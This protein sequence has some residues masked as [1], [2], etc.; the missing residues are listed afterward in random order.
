M[1]DGHMTYVRTTNLTY[2]EFNTLNQNYEKVRNALISEAS[3][4][5]F[6]VTGPKPMDVFDTKLQFSKELQ[7]WKTSWDRLFLSTMEILVT[8]E[9]LLK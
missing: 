9:G 1:S 4:I 6:S 5:T 7:K 2:N 3:K 8:R